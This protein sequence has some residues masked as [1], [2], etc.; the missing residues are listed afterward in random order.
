LHRRRFSE[1]RSEH[2]AVLV[3]FVLVFPVFLLLVFG[4]IDV[5][6]LVNGAGTFRSGTEEAASFIADGDTSSPSDPCVI[7]LE[8]QGVDSDTAGAVCEVSDNIG[9]PTGLDMST[10]QL[11]IVC[12]NSTGQVVLDSSGQPTCA[13]SQNPT[14]ANTPSS[15]V[16]CAR[17]KAHSDTGLLSPLLDGMWVDASGAAPIS[18]VEYGPNFSYYNADATGPS[19][20]VCPPSPVYTVTFDANGGTGS[21]SPE[22]NSIPATLTTNSF[23]GPNGETF[24]GWNTAPDGSGQPYADGAEY[25]FQASMTLYAQWG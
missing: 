15:F 11:A 10:L 24:V 6:L 1:C 25:S 20:L 5:A 7:T 9:S 13:Y 17:A 23:S 18:A 19:P 3:E 4:G 2:G 21:M 16:V 8:G 14:P 22:T 12:L